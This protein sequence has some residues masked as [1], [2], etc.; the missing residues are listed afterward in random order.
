MKKNKFLRIFMLIMV[1]SLTLGLSILATISSSRANTDSPIVGASP[2]KVEDRF[3]AEPGEYI[4]ES[5]VENLHIPWE[6]IFLSDEKALVTERAGS[7]R[8]IENGVLQEKP[9][10]IIDEVE[11]IGEGGLMGLT[12]HPDYPAQKYLYVMYTYRDNRAL[13]N[14]VA[15]YI[16]SGDSMEFDR[17]IIKKI[18]ASNVH[19]GGR[20][21]FGPDGLLYITTGDTWHSEIAQNIDIL[22]GKILRLTADGDMPADNPFPGSPVYSFGHRNPQGL[23]WHPETGVLFSSEHGPTGE[24]GLYSRDEVNIIEKGGNYGWPLVVGAAGVESYKDP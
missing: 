10:K 23:A 19:N 11:H 16:D 13:Y 22:G 12:K 8:L 7:V 6:L 15:R 1:F 21:A 9:Y 14:R 5:W 20:I 2:Q 24:F 4:V 17:L 3:V 18:P